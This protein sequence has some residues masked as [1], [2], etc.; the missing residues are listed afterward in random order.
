MVDIRRSGCVSDVRARA[1]V[2]LACPMARLMAYGPAPSLYSSM[3]SDF[4]HP[5]EQFR[6]SPRAKPQFVPTACQRLCLGKAWFWILLILIRLVLICLNMDLDYTRQALASSH[7]N[8]R[9]VS[10]GTEDCSIALVWRLV[11]ALQGWKQRGRI[12][13]C[14]EGLWQQAYQHDWCVGPASP[15]LRIVTGS[16]LHD[17]SIS[18]GKVLTLL[19]LDPSFCMQCSVCLLF[20]ASCIV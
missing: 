11:S 7:D 13:R 5:R 17:L 10:G 14:R 9:V 4:A 15:C 16:S 2:N 18:C 8:F 6:A 20:C 12:R 19:S 1:A 3:K